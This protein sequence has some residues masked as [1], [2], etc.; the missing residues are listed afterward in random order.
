MHVFLQ[1]AFNAD[2]LREHMREEWMAVYDFSYIDDKIIGGI[3]KN[4]PAISDILK[5][6]ERR[7]TGKVSTALSI[8]SGDHDDSEGKALTEGGLTAHDQSQ[9]LAAGSTKDEIF[10]DNGEG[11]KPVKKTEF[12]PFNITKPKPKLI[13][14]PEAI[15]R[16]VKARPM[17]KNFNKKTLA[18]IEADKMKRR[19]ATINAVKDEY[20]GNM[21]KRF[22]LQTE[23]RPTVNKFAKAKDEA[24]V[25]FTKELKF[26][27]VKARPM[28]KFE[29]KEAN[30]KLNVAALKREKA[31]IDKEEQELEQK[32]KEMAMGLKDASEFNRW[33]SEM[34]EKDDIERL[35]HI[36]KKKIEME[37]AR[38]EAILARE[39]KEKENQ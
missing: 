1:F 21:K 11:E 6:V 9:S 14:A 33:K 12:V 4:L 10:S 38:E 24:E 17:P 13:P 20:E 37:L 19:K 35:E 34:G 28:P 29:Q 30:V 16:E 31:L 3:E 2:L 26:D 23:G 15:K 32:V 18:D 8:R 22:A 5:S 27:G 39:R 36:Q 25:R 7:A